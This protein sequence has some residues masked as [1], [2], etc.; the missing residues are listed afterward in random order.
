MTHPRPPIATLALSLGLIT[1]TLTAA[2]TT[3]AFW[4]R[5]HDA[6]QKARAAQAIRQAPDTFAPYTFDGARIVMR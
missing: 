6:S 3:L 1:L 4:D 2:I 5:L